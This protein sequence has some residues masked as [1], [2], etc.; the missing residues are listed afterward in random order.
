MQLPIAA[1]E[2]EI[3]MSTTTIRRLISGA[4]L[5]VVAV[6]MSACVVEPAPGPYYHP[7]HYYYRY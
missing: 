2:G 3:K 7:Y 4:L 5:A 6:A 1:L